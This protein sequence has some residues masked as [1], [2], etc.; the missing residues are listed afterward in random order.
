MTEQELIKTN[1]LQSS[2]LIC[3]TF[4]TCFQ[5]LCYRKKTSFFPTESE[6]I[7]SKHT[8]KVTSSF[9]HICPT[10]LFTSNTKSAF[11]S[12][13]TLSIYLTGNRESHWTQLEWTPAASWP[14]HLT[15]TNTV[16][17]TQCRT[18]NPR[19]IV[20]YATYRSQLF[21]YIH[22]HLRST[23]HLQYLWTAFPK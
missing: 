6:V 10:C 12:L 14:T 8:R 17:R 19:T 16:S 11:S 2:T 21:T 7:W 20:V 9:R 4:S 13:N 1:F 18:Y 23:V 15:S 22:V 3:Q 5:S